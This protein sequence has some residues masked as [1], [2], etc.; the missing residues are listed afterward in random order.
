MATSRKKSPAA[1]KHKLSL[2]VD[3][4]NIVFADMGYLVKNGVEDFEPHADDASALAVLALPEGRKTLRVR[5]D[6]DPA[7]D[8]R[9]EIDVTS[10]R[11]YVGDVSHAFSDDD[12]Y[13]RFLKKTKYLSV[14]NRHMK[15]FDTGGDGEFRVVIE[16][17]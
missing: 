7:T 14:A 1:N 2:G 4:G 6:T 8:E 12:A 15:P 13:Q 10:G 16:I 11:L 5:I 9:F 17:L 3:A